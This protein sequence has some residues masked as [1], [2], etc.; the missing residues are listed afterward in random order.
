MYS[1]TL[2]SHTLNLLIISLSIGLPIILLIFTLILLTQ[3]LQPLNLYSQHHILALQ[4]P[5]PFSQTPPI[6]NH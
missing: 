6:L 4:H 1:L 3:I 2:S 5:N